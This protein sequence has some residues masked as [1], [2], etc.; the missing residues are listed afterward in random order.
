MHLCKSISEKNSRPIPTNQDQPHHRPH[1]A[2]KPHRFTLIT[3]LP[4]FIRK[5]S[6]HPYRPQ[7]KKEK[8]KKEKKKKH[9]IA[10]PNPSTAKSLHLQQLPSYSLHSPIPT[11]YSKKPHRSLI[12]KVSVRLFFSKRIKV[13]DSCV[14][15][16]Q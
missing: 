4:V 5:C 16:S 15:F 1:A 13:V 2:T 9:H 3:V 11:P 8:E 6:F 14:P 10:C 12:S 7:C